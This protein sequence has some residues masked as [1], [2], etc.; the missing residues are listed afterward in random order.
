MSAVATVAGRAAAGGVVLALLFA[1]AAVTGELTTGAVVALLIAVPV[2]AFRRADDPAPVA[3]LVA[4][5]FGA[6]DRARRVERG[7]PANPTIA[8]RRPED[9]AIEEVRACDA[10]FLTSFVCD[11]S[12][13][14]GLAL[15]C[16]R[17]VNTRTFVTEGAAAATTATSSSRAASAT[18]ATSSAGAASATFEAEEAE[19][20]DNAL[21]LGGFICDA[22]S[23]QLGAVR[24]RLVV[25]KTLTFVAAEV[26]ATSSSRATRSA[27]TRGAAIAAVVTAD[28]KRSHR[29]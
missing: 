14:R 28:G 2:W 21:F 24:C 16:H 4:A 20:G 15:H 27:A 17:R 25:R 1:A 10:L 13:D 12:C 3:L 6:T 5:G 7:A 22:S 18:A 29:E 23:D 19:A 9:I 26:G 11:A 8:V